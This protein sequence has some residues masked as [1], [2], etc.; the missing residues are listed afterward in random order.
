MHFSASRSLTQPLLGC[1]RMLYL[2]LTQYPY[3]PGTL[4]SSANQCILG[5]VYLRSNLSRECCQESYAQKIM[6]FGAVQQKLWSFMCRWYLEW[7][8]HSNAIETWYCAWSMR[9]CAPLNS[10]CQR[11]MHVHHTPLNVDCCNIADNFDIKVVQ[12]LLY[13]NKMFV[14][15]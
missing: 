15:R 11:N 14:F 1:I 12:K 6:S 10:T 3:D 13:S 2:T 7:S 4:P 5:K 9:Q 8:V